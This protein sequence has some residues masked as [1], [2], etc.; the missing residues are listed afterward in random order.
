[1]QEMGFTAGQ[2]AQAAAES[3]KSGLRFNSPLEITD[4]IAAGCCSGYMRTM[5]KPDGYN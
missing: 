3:M 2:A 4:E 5:C 1:M